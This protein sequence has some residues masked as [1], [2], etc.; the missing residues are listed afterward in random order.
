MRVGAGGAE[1]SLLGAAQGGVCVAQA[2]GELP[3]HQPGRGARWGRSFPFCALANRGPS[4]LAPSTITEVIGVWTRAPAD[5]TLS[6]AANQLCLS[7]PICKMGITLSYCELMQVECTDQARVHG[8]RSPTL[9]VVLMHPQ[10]CAR[11]PG[12]R[13][14]VKRMARLSLRT[15]PREGSTLIPPCPAANIVGSPAVV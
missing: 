15:A 3:T 8:R 5:G 14:A 11:C 13:Q 6:N 4:S 12:P 1:S 9:A 7:F 10:V 2:S